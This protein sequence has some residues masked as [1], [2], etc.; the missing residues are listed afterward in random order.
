MFFSQVF[1]YAYGFSGAYPLDFREPLRLDLHYLK[2]PV[3][4]FIYDAFREAF[5]DSSDCSGT[6]VSIKCLRIFRSDLLVGADFQ[7][8]AE[9]LVHRKNARDLQILTCRQ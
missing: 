9:A 4:E 7:L 5:A 8:F 6:Q 1:S 3:A 2:S